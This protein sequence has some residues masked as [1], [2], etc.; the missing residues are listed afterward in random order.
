VKAVSA[1]SGR[2]AIVPVTTSTGSWRMAA[3]LVLDSPSSTAD[4]FLLGVTGETTRATYKAEFPGCHAVVGRVGLG[5]LCRGVPRGRA[6]SPRGC[7]LA[8]AAPQCGHPSSAD[9]VPAPAA[10]PRRVA[11]G[12]AFELPHRPAH[13]GRGR[14]KGERALH[15]AAPR[16]GGFRRGGGPG[17]G[18]RSAGG[19]G[20][21]L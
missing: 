15:Q 17:Q 16:N 8:R 2:Q 20:A 11:R 7:A 10:G 12:A 19:I 6:S 5:G 18:H 21:L 9:L 14:L 13:L 1:R 4:P 3:L